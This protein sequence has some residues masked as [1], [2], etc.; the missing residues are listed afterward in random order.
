MCCSKINR[1]LTF[2]YSLHRLKHFSFMP[3]CHQ[4]IWNEVHPKNRASFI[5]FPLGMLLLLWSSLFKP[6][7]KINAH[8]KCEITWPLKM[9]PV[10]SNL[11]CHAENYSR[12]IQ[13]FK[14]HTIRKLKKCYKSQD[15]KSCEK[16]WYES[17]I[18]N[19]KKKGN[20]AGWL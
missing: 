5:N 17:L 4:F 14:P 16:S 15:S 2:N 20:L 18:K 12:W 11:I 19:M 3:F 10:F 9:L 13:R 7:S 6:G 8:K 1:F